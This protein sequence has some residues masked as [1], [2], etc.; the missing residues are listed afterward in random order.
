KSSTAEPSTTGTLA[1]VGDRQRADLRRSVAVAR[2]TAAVELEPELRVL[3]HVREAALLAH[4][5]FDDR[6]ARETVG[7]TA[8]SATRTADLPADESVLLSVA[9]ALATR[10]LALVVDDVDLRASAHQQARIWRALRSVADAG[11]AVVAST[12]DADIAAASG[13]SVVRMGEGVDGRD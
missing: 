6:W 3:D 8:D 2:I 13:A 10:P 7:S 12:V 1:V 11:T 5:D 9:L 4:G